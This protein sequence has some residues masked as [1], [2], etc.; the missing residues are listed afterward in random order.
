MALADNTIARE[1]ELADV[2]T[3][4]GQINAVDVNALVD[5]RFDDDLASVVGPL[6]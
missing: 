2:F 1:Q 4:D 5:E 6:P 3:E